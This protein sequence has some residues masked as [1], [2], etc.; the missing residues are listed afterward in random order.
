[1]T[2][3]VV[4]VHLHA[5]LIMMVTL[6][7][8]IEDQTVADLSHLEVTV[9]DVGQDLDRKIIEGQVPAI[10]KGAI[11]HVITAIL[12]CLQ[13]ILLCLHLLSL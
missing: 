13:A 5:V 11:V 2:A 1:M 3:V 8:T 7:I 9:A 10:E 4:V 6:T 12:L